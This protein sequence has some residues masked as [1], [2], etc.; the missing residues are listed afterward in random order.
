MTTIN[1]IAQITQDAILKK[2]KEEDEY[3][4][5]LINRLKNYAEQGA[6]STTFTINQFSEHTKNK[7]EKDGFVV[8]KR[9]WNGMERTG[10]E[11]PTPVSYLVWDISW[12]HE[13]KT[14]K[15]G[16]KI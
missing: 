12:G 13:L 7:L 3:Y 14:I 8:K 4:L 11:T 9:I 10:R 1:E 2:N 6:L 16:T 5:V 15:S